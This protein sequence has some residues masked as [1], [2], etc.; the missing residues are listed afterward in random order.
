MKT[1]QFFF[2]VMVLWGVFSPAAHAVEWQIAWSDEFTSNG[3]PNPAY[4]DYE[5]GFKRNHEKQYYTRERLENARV[6]NG[7]LIIE[8]RKEKYPNAHANPGPKNWS[9]DFA[10]YTAASLITKGKVEMTYG[11]LEVRAELP[12]GAGTWPAIWMLGN[13]YGEGWPSCGEIDI[14][15]FVGQKPREL[16]FNIH[17][18]DAKEQE[19]HG[20]AQKVFTAPKPITGFHVYA[21]EWFPDRIDYYF[22]KKKVHAFYLDR[23]GKGNENPFRHPQY[24]LLN[25]ALG[26]EWGKEIDDSK[27]PQQYKIDYVRIYRGKP[28]SGK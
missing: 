1:T 20:S 11:R 9:P 13:S 27:L 8:A 24:L 15:E 7:M 21:I 17:Y 16:S 26:G 25:L 4:W 2:I 28:K 5:E 6:E 19:K 12:Q 14:M 22:D 10:S 18:Y 3:L 23:A